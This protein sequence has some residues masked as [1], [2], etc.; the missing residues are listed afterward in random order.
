MVGAYWHHTANTTDQSVQSSD[1][2]CHYH[3]CSNVV[4]ITVMLKMSAAVITKKFLYGNVNPST[5]NN[6]GLYRKIS[7]TINTHVKLHRKEKL[8][9]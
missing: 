5:A 3:Y 8:A 1:A 4:I 2:G 6:I 9:P 7:T